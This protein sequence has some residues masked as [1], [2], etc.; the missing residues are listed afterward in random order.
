MTER[1]VIGPKPGD[2]YAERIKRLRGEIGL[3][4]QVLAERLGVSFATV[5][6]WEN[7]QTKPSRLYWNQLQQLE[8]R[9]A[10]DSAPYGKKKERPPAILD[11]TAQPEVVKVLAEGERLSFGHLMNPTFATEISSIDPLPHQRIAVYDHMLKQ[12]RLRFLLADDAGAGKTIMSGLYI[13]EML[14]RRLLRRIL[15]VTPA[16]LVGNWRRELLTLFNLP[17][18]IVTGPDARADNP[19]QGEAGDRIIIS[20]DTLSSPRMFARLRE[21]TVVPYDLVIFD[22]AHK[23]AADRGNDLRVRKT[24]RYCLAEALAG[25]QSQNAHWRLG[26]SAHHLL[27]LT[28]TPHMGKDYPYYATWRL[29][30]PEMLATPD[31]FDE[32]PREHRQSHFIRRTKEEMVFLDGRPLYPKRMSD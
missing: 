8:M 11:F 32:Y 16:G 17:F 7:H 4:Q 19:F 10:E 27:L 22:E 5:N 18:R 24:D 1:Y 14:S 2:D 25:I 29:L 31:A 6:R 20:I 28:A 23:L 21:T 26:W 3:T 30:E 15:I 9:V 12:P 13:R